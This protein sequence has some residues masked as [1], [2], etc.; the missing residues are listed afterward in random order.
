M[1]SQLG[2]L[3]RVPTEPPLGPDCAG[4]EHTCMCA[5]HRWLC[6]HAYVSCILRALGLRLNV[7]CCKDRVNQAGMSTTT[8]ACRTG[9]N[10][11]PHQPEGSSGS[12]PPSH[13]NFNQM[14]DPVRSYAWLQCTS[15]S[16]PLYIYCTLYTVISLFLLLGSQ[17]THQS[18]PERH[19]CEQIC[20]PTQADV[21]TC[22]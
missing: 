2:A 14:Q 15:C 18:T 21:P 4:G 3:A 7:G 6:K 8:C 20:R 10:A 11:R 1:K 17:C 22:S 5:M 19:R 9:R 16:L 12:M 13:R